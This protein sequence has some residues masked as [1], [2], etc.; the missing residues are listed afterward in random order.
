VPEAGG[1]RTLQ[2]TAFALEARDLRVEPMDLGL[3]VPDHGH[4]RFHT[5]QQAEINVLTIY[6]IKNVTYNLY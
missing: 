2:G 3:G 4:A 6:D 1:P 5:S